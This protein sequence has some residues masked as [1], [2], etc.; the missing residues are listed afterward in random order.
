MAKAEAAP[1]L[2]WWRWMVSSFIDGSENQWAERFGCQSVKALGELIDNANE[3]KCRA[4]LVAVVTLDRMVNW[5]GELSE[6]LIEACEFYKIDH[7]KLIADKQAEFR[8]ADKTN[9]E[10]VKLKTDAKPQAGTAKK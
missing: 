6:S 10:L 4:T 5:Q 7:K 8:I 3:A 9:A 2:N 1:T